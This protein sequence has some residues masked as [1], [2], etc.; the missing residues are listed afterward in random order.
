VSYWSYASTACSLP[1]PHTPTNK[2]ELP[3]YQRL[4]PTVVRETLCRD[5]AFLPTDYPSSPSSGQGS[6]L[7]TPRSIDGTG[8]SVNQPIFPPPQP[9]YLALILFPISPPLRHAPHRI[10]YPSTISL[11][12]DVFYNT[13]WEGSYRVNSFI[14]FCWINSS[15]FRFGLSIASGVLGAGK[16][17]GLELLSYPDL[18][19][20]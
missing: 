17:I 12:R 15:I 16:R 7:S 13:E 2:H 5:L 11:S 10:G 14:L 18:G 20:L 6:F 9:A 4:V 3:K 8:F 1:H 19:D